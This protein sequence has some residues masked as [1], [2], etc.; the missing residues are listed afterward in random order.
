MY[1]PVFH[2]I[3]RAMKELFKVC[4]ERAETMSYNLIVRNFESQ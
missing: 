1:D 2:Y 4:E 3:C